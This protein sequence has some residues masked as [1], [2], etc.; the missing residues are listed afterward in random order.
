M[1]FKNR[2]EAGALLA[3][4]LKDYKDSK[5]TIVLALPRGG[6]SVAYP[7]AKELNL[8]LSLFFTK[9]IPSPYN[10]EVAIGAISE[11]NLL[12]LNKYAIDTLSI[13]KDYIDKKSIEILKNINDKKRLYGVLKIDVKDKNVILVDDGIATGASVILASNA[14]KKE[15][16]KE[17]IVASPVAPSE[18]KQTLCEQFK[19]AILHYD[20]NLIAVGRFYEDF[21]QLDDSEVIGFMKEFKWK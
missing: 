6:V 11:N 2:Q 17:I 16:A 21:H 1:L 14:L 7:I 13:S 12:W 8:P 5:D 15:G 19:C 20:D 3:K 18:I 9:K 10:K 4:K